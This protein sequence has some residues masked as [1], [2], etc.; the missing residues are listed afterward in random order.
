MTISAKS[1]AEMACVLTLAF[2]PMALA[3]TPVYLNPSAPFDTRVSDLLSRMTLEEKISQLMNDSAA[4]PRLKVPA[5]NWWNE[6][7]HGVARAGRATVFPETIGLAATWDKDLIF[8]AATAISD[9]ARAKNNDFVRRGKR[10][11][12]QGLTFWTPN[13]NLFRDPRWGRGMETYGEDPYLTGRL[14]V[15]FIKGLQGDDPKYLKTVATAKHYAVHSGPESE[16]HTFDARIDDADLRDTYLPQFE[17]AIREG[18]AQSVMCAYNSVDGAPACANPPLLEQILRKQWGFSGY[19][20]SDCGAIGDIY[21]H[22]KF[23]STAELGVAKA[24]QA[25]TDLNCG[26]EYE[27]LLPAVKQGALRE[28]DIDQAVRRLLTARFRL[29]MFDPPAI[30]KY[31][32]IPI[33]V[34]DSP[35]HR[36]L[37]LEAA[38][39]S[40]VLL[41]NENRALP[42]AKSIKTIAVIGPDAD[43]LDA[44]T[45]NYNGD[46][47]AP[48][49]PLAGIR[50]KL[51]NARV[52]YARGSDLAANMPSFETV[53]TSAL[54]TSNT[55][56]RRNG[57]TGEYYNSSNFDGKPHR[58]RELTYPNS[59]KMVGEVPR[60]MKPLFSRVDPQ[61]DFHWLDGAPRPGMNDDDFGVRWTGY[62]AAPVTGTYQ[63]GA[64]GLN[65]FELYL[66]GKPIV[67]FNN[68]HEHSYRYEEVK[69]EAGKLYAIRLDYHEF[70]NDADIALV[71]SRPVDPAARWSETEAAVKAADSVVLVL[72]LSPRLEG[73]EMKVPVEGFSGG[74]RVSL[75]IPRSQQDLMERVVALGKPTTLVLMNGSAVSVNWARDHVPAIVE[76]WYPGESGGAALAD[77][78]FGDYNPAGRLP[79]TFYKSAGQ[80]PAF[81]DYNMKGRTYRFFTGDPLFPFGYGLSYTTFAYRNL[82]APSQ[83][84]AGD[85][86]TVTVEV[87]NTG[88][89]AG[90][91][92]VQL[93]LKPPARPGAPLRSL[94]G[95]E[96]IALRP[97]ERKTVTFH[98]EPRQFSST[99]VNGKRMV[100]PG[101]FAVIVGAAT[102]TV[103]LNGL[104]REIN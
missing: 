98:L 45:G 78:L 102:A 56:S 35:A 34:N 64:I 1:A 54:F 74:D 25:G 86:I 71:W 36:Q 39:K 21:L 32:Q 15:Q 29:G 83:S 77:V 50:R 42:L 81:T 18:G 49:T 22:H 84:N 4:I 19:V 99:G 94:E 20:V 37:A 59:G 47:S 12:Y 26:V 30:V 68:I 43:D 75:D 2:A 44:L 6:C 53:P 76:A 27:A 7:L 91:D 33:S 80:L 14:A 63:L 88:K 82:R 87:E 62:L 57:L 96:R 24:V 8:R 104:P 9:E 93:Y 70:L 10:N 28:A 97:A 79:V 11:I 60:D 101:D 23:S 67:N 73:E 65:A 5:Y 16:R 17:A 95:F 89:V 31:A 66:D 48:I 58:P 13:I 72:G 40:I 38:R 51:P 69:L 61:I 3:Q 52:L 90:E 100:Q 103:R 46:P 92:V 55:T 85:G 41:K